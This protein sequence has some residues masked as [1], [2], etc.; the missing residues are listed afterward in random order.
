M[1]NRLGFTLLLMAAAMLILSACSG[2]SGKSWDEEAVAA[3]DRILGD[4]VEAAWTVEP[5][6]AAGSG[7]TIRLALTRTDGRTI[8]SFDITHEKLLHLI[9]VSQDL[10]Y[11]AH[12]HPEHMGGGVFEAAND[13]PAGG[14]Y[15]L[16]ADFKPTGG[17]S[18]TKMAWV[19]VAGEPADD[20]PVVPDGITE[21]VADGNRVALAAA[22]GESE[23]E[24]SLTFTLTD[25]ATGEPV[26]DLEPY[27]GAIGH[28]VILSADGEKYVH[29]HAEAGQGSGPTA[30]FEAALPGSG[31]YKV[32]GQFQRGGEV[33]T[34][35][36]VL[37]VAE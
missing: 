13:F 14:A 21:Q 5:E 32:W 35:P 23:D 29:V 9:V 6:A 20:V 37:D 24:L 31:V 11:F 3:S 16:I 26:T 4:N 30:A 7:E 27:L 33:F 8:D 2:G 34:V 10:S 19:E 28:V 1:N 15:R 25:E 17:D 12:I 22:D 18:M 36:Y